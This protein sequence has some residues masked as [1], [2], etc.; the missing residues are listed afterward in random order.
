MRRFLLRLLINALGL[1]A[2]VIL[3]PQVAPGITWDGSWLTLV[4]MA[5]I[6]AVVNAF[7]RPLLSILTCPLI[8]L[9]LGLFTLVIN[10]LIL[11][12]AGLLGQA[13]GLGFRIEGFVPAF[14]GALIV[15]TVNVLATLL[16]G[17]EIRHRRR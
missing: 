16:L 9:T 11:W 15:S 14:L 5:L 2:A 1:Y 4:V 8:I 13:L 3:V 12:L 7:V 17:D 6:L 10:A